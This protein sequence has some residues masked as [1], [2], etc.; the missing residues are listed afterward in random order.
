MDVGIK[1]EPAFEP[2]FT[3]DEVAAA[4]GMTLEEVRG[5]ESEGEAIAAM[6]AGAAALVKEAVGQGRIDA[7]ISIGCSMG[8]S[9]GLKVMRDLPVTL[10]KLMLSSIAFTTMVTTESVSIDQVMMQTVGDLWGL[11]PITRMVL[12]R[13]AGAIC[14]MLEAQELEKAT[15]LPVVGITILGV[16]DYAVH[17]RTLLQARLEQLLGQVVIPCEKCS[18]KLRVPRGKGKI[19]V[20]CPSC[21]HQQITTA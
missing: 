1:D 12:Q 9:L 16:H 19:K 10:P 13:S 20:T 8:T 6:A 18:T 7:V 3:H 4:V 5:S 2:D 17:C 11:N 14:G 21:Q 15:D